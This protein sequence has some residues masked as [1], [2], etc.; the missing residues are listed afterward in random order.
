MPANEDDDFDLTALSRYGS[1]STSD[2]RARKQAETHTP[3]VSD[4]RR[5]RTSDRTV[6]LGMKVT[7]EFKRWLS[8]LATEAG[9]AQVEYV[10]QAV[11]LRAKQSGRQL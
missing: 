7:P 4:R 9:E 3:P 1:G 6:Q 5:I 8:T 10:E 11:M 2:P